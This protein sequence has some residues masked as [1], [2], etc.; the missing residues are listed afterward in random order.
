MK[1]ETAQDLTMDDAIVGSTGFVGG[2]L[3]RR[4]AFSGQF[5]SRT[6]HHA[7]DQAFGVV[8]CAAAPGSMFEA[9]RFPDVDKARIDTLIDHLSAIRTQRFVLISSIAVLADC[10]GQVDEKTSSFETKLAYGRNRRALEVFCA[11]RFERCLIVRLPALFGQGLKK[12]FLFDILNPMPSM[13][14]EASFAQLSEQCPAELR[15]GLSEFYGWNDSLKLFSIDREALAATGRRAAYD[16]AVTEMG[17]SA[18]TFTNP[19]NQFQYY[20]MNRLWADIELCLRSEL[21]VIHLAPEPLMAG[22]IFAAFTGRT[23]AETAARLH[24]EDM[25]TRHATLF[26]REGPYIAR[27]TEIME[28]LKRFFAEERTFA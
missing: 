1:S 2:H 18:V 28:L 16:A 12:N 6:V 20:D 17:L 14:T 10:A 27:A 11:E 8:V 19:K 23:M 15:T 13:L 25:W 21:D 3:V 26:G 9:N 7:A 22:E 5:N 24:R 4:H